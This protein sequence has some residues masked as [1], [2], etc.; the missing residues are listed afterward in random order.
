[1]AGFTLTVTQRKGGVGRSYA[2]AVKSRAFAELLVDEVHRDDSQ[3]H[4]VFDPDDLQR[5]ADSIKR[6]RWVV[7]VGERRLRA[8]KLAGLDRVRVEFVEREPNKP[9]RTSFA[10][11]SL[12]R[13][14]SRLKCGWLHGAG[15]GRRIKRRAE[16]YQRARLPGGRWPAWT[17]SRGLPTACTRMAGI[18]ARAVT[19][20]E[21]PKIAGADQSPPGPPPAGGAGVRVPRAA[22]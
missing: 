18:D 11:T 16:R 22:S 17:R 5:L 6:W 9:S 4:R 19:P 20:P 1:M 14:K 10:P 2:G 15:L 3:P 21:G 8:C 13:A 7:L 12:T